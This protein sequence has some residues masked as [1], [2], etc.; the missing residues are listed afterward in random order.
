MKER[1]I[2]ALMGRITHEADCLITG[3]KELYDNIMSGMPGR[4]GE[5]AAFHIPDGRTQELSEQFER[6]CRAIA[7]RKI[8]KS[9][10]T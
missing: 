10:N 6:A 4:A 5:D 9:G 7:A 2:T 1:F 8:G 3:D